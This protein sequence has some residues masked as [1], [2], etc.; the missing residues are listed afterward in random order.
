MA[1]TPLGCRFDWYSCTADGLDEQLVASKLA[2]A[3]GA[4]MSQGKG[5]NGYASCIVLERDDA[6]LAQVYGRSARAGEVHIVVTSESCDELVPIVRRL[7]PDHRVARADISV[8][9]AADFEE[10]DKRAVQLVERRGV[11]HRLMVNSDGGATRYLGAVSSETAV[12]VYK[13]SEQLRSLHPERA[14]SIP[15]GIVRVELVVRPS[16]AELKGRAS[17]MEPDEF[18]GL[19]QWTQVF[20]VEMLSIDAERIPTH[21]R[22][23]SEW[24]RALHFLGEQWGPMMARRSEAVGRA[25]V[26]AQVLEALGLSEDA[27]MPF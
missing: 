18:W 8:D 16:K 11:S 27:E 24:S 25:E 17:Q 7:Y 19:G 14:D 10:L 13:K 1:S 15:D 3:T 23:P 2:A 5:R 4:K 22:R 20:A 26:I 12:R 9:F 6:T 21:F